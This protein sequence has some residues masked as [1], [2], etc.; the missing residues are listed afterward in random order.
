M[1]PKGRDEEREETKCLREEGG[2]CLQ[3]VALKYVVTLEP[4]TLKFPVMM[5]CPAPSPMSMRFVAVEGIVTIS[6]YNPAFTR[7]V[8]LLALF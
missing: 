8:H 7:M 5:V 2:A 4:P 6:L 3:T 1:R